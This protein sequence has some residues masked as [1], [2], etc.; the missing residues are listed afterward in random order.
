M[1]PVIIKEKI[2]KKRLAEI[3]KEN[4]GEM[5]KADVDIKQEVIALGGEWHSEGDDLLVK[6]GSFREDIWGINFYPW[7]KP[8]KRVEYISLINIKP[9]LGNRSMEIRDKIVKKRIN[10]VVHKLLLDSSENINV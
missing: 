1:E 10:F 3:T 8:E 4:F 6:N 5:V 9:A 7:N 2:S